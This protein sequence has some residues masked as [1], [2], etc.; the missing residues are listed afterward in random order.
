MSWVRPKKI[1]TLQGKVVQ[2]SA[3]TAPPSRKRQRE[4]EE[5]LEAL[6]AKVRRLETLITPGR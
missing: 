5:E 1:T 4:E 3:Q 6:H 2:L